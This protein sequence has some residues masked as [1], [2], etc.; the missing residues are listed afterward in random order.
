MYI[1]GGVK[2][3]IKGKTQGFEAEEGFSFPVKRQWVDIN[4]FETRTFIYTPFSYF[5]GASLVEVS[6][7]CRYHCSF[8]AGRNI[9]H[10]LRNRSLELIE[11]MI[12]HVSPWSDKIGLVGADLLSHR[13][14][15]NNKVRV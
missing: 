8:C 1:P 9:Y 4:E 14:G 15:R 6:R 7:G 3:F 12:D 2:P 11:K 10:P 13:L 5:Q